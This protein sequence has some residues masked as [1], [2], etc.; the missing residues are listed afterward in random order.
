[1]K[2]KIWTST[3]K[4][5]LLQ[6]FNLYFKCKLFGLEIA[7]NDMDLIMILVQFFQLF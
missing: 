7:C 3:S 5:H 6:P 4:N 2:L 1:M